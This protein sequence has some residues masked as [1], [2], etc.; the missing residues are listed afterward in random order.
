[1]AK[2]F[3]ERYK[4]A[5][6]APAPTR[7]RFSREL[8]KALRRPS[9][10][11]MA[12]EAPTD[13]SRHDVGP[14]RHAVASVYDQARGVYGTEVDKVLREVETIRTAMPAQYQA[15]IARPA[16]VLNWHLPHSVSTRRRAPWISRFVLPAIFAWP[17]R[18]L[19]LAFALAALRS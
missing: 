9:L 10:E 8:V 3:Y 2:L 14:F 1:V 7:Q 6:P 19:M 11:Q 15:L 17:Q 18:V 4:D 12:A 5:S 16:E 13:P